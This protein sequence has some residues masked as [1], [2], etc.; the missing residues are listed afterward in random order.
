MMDYKIP[1]VMEIPEMFPI[2][3]DGDTRQMVLGVGEPP[4]VPATAAIANAV[5]NAC[6]VRIRDLPI[7][8]DKILMA[9]NPPAQA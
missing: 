3:D 9:L 6:G 2:I 8:C 1:G 7:S 4:G 5:F